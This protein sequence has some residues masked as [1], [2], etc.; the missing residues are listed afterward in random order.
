MVIDYND[1]L[2]LRGFFSSQQGRVAFIESSF[3]A[4]HQFQHRTICK[5][6]NNIV[7]RV[8]RKSC[9]NVYTYNRQLPERKANSLQILLIFCVFFTS[10]F[11]LMECDEF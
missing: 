10:F 9:K 6:L 1:L 2:G 11:T 3:Q 4:T 7:Y 5:F 8:Y